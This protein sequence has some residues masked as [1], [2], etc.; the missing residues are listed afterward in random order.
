MAKELIELI[1]P[2]GWVVVPIAD[3]DKM[4]RKGYKTREEHMKDSK[5]KEKKKAKGK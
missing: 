2:P 3:L 4:K 5:P 1:G